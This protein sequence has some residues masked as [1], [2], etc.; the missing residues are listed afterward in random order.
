MNGF[1]PLPYK[2]RPHHPAKIGLSDK[3]MIAIVI[4]FGAICLFS[5]C[6]GSQVQ[7]TV[8]IGLFTWDDRPVSEVLSD[9]AT[10][11]TARASSGGGIGS[12][13]RVSSD[14]IQSM[15]LHKSPVSASSNSTPISLDI[16]LVK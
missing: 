2:Y 7:C 3:L 15:V 6:Y 8:R 12:N 10:N 1:I 11:F 9:D 5:G 14:T 16:P 4:A 13:A